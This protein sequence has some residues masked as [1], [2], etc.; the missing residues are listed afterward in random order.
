M[1]AIIIILKHKTLDYKQWILF[2]SPNREAQSNLNFFNGLSL[3][4]TAFCA[5][6][7]PSFTAFKGTT[8][9]IKLP[10]WRVLRSQCESVGKK[11]L[12]GIS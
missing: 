1:A 10:K 3:S 12:F 4:K 7:S 9:K 11:S 2:V 5:Q 8:N 6:T